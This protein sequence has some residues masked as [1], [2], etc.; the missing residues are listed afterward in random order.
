MRTSAAANIAPR[1]NPKLRCHVSLVHKVTFYRI[2][3]RRDM[4]KTTQ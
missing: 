1:L 4:T 3:L 2:D